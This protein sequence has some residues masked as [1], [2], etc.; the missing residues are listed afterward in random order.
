M[1]VYLIFGYSNVNYNEI[2]SALIYGKDIKSF[3]QI[4][5]YIETNNKI[6]L[7]FSKGIHKIKKKAEQIACE[8]ALKLVEKQIF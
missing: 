3:K 2:N 4:H 5:E 7:F 8:N 1:G 6:I